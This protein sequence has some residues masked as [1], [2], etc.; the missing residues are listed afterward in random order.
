MK[1]FLLA[2]AAAA[3]FS[4]V[5]FGQ[6]LSSINP[7]SAEPGQELPITITCSGDNFVTCTQMTSWTVCNSNVAGVYMRNGDSLL[8]ASSVSNVQSTSLTATFGFPLSCA[9]GAWDVGVGRSGGTLWQS[10]GFAVNPL[11]APV[12]DSISPKMSLQNRSLA[13]TIFGTHTHFRLFQQS[14]SVDNVSAAWLKRGVAAVKADSVRPINSCTVQAYFTLSSSVDSGR[15]DVQVDQGGGLAS[16]TLPKAF[17]VTWPFSPSHPLP[18]GCIAYYPLDGDAGDYSNN[19]NDGTIYG[20]TAADGVYGGALYFDGSS[21][22][23][24][25]PDNGGFTITNGLSICAWIKPEQ[26]DMWYRVVGKT[27]SSSSNNDWVLGQAMAGGIYFS[28]WKGASQYNTNGGNPLVLNAWNHIAGT[29]DGTCMRIYYNGSVQPESVLVAPPINSSGNPLLIGK[30]A[31]NTYYFKGGIDE[32]MIFNR[33]LTGAEIDSIYR[34]A[35]SANSKA[36]STIPVLIPCEPKVTLNLRP[37]FAW[38]KVTGAAVYTLAVATDL[39][40]ANIVLQTPL[41]DTSYAS[42]A[43]MPLGT[44]FWRVKSDLNTRWSPYDKFVIQS[45]TVPYLVRFNGDT[46]ESKRPR[47]IWNKVAKATAYRVEIASSQTFTPNLVSTLCQDTFFLP[48]VDMTQG[49]YF[50]HVSCDRNYEIYCAPDSL[51]VGSSVHII[52]TGRA[53]RQDGF[54]GRFA[55]LIGRASGLELWIYEPNGK[56]AAVIPSVNLRPGIAETLKASGVRLPSGVYLA[57]LKMSGVTVAMKK[58]A[59]GQ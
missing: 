54:L 28:M 26:A 52:G 48:L 39:A 37:S 23:I 45:D 27:N 36:D 38:H 13:M 15:Y 53:V 46:V 25:V 30:M 51:A 20:A 4:H 41:S 7:S 58:F 55:S 5:S 18:K 56:R 6:S 22:Y 47:F 31:D 1:R 12:L 8:T 44:I 2:V 24:S 33:A 29:W 19:G 21:S 17:T 50:W 16:A 14:A 49:T 32:I 11:S 57:V 35:Y 10:Q 42:L 40:F 34:G 3:F 9:T 59:K 43:N